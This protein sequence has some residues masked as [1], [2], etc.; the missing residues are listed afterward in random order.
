MLHRD[1]LKM[2]THE[3]RV[4]L[5]ARSPQVSVGCERAILRSRSGPWL[6]AVALVAITDQARNIVRNQ[7]IIALAVA[8]CATTTPDATVAELPVEVAGPARQTLSLDVSQLVLGTEGTFTVTGAEEGDVIDILRG[9]RI[10]FGYCPTYLGGNC[11]DITGGQITRIGQ[12]TAD[13]T[14]TAVYAVDLP[15]NPSIAGPH[16]F[17][18]VIRQGAAVSGE[19]NESPPILRYATIPV[20]ETDAFEPNDDAGSAASLSTGTTDAVSCV[21]EE[22]FYELQIAPDQILQVDAFYDPDDGSVAL[23][24]LDSAGASLDASAI[25]AS[26]ETVAWRNDLGVDETVTLRVSAIDDRAL[27]GIPYSLA[28]ELI[29]PAPC[30][31]DPHEPNDDATEATSLASPVQGAI[32]CAGDPD[33]YEI[34]VA[35]EGLID[36]DI[37]FD[38]AEGSVGAKLY[39]SAGNLLGQRAPGPNRID[40]SY[41]T[42]TPGSYYLHV[43]QVSDDTFGGG[44]PYAVQAV[45]ANLDICFSDL[46]EN[47]N[48]SAFSTPITAGLYEA[49]GGCAAD[50]NDW[51]VIDVPANQTLTVTAR[52]AHGAGN[53]D[54]RLY[55]LPPP[56]GYNGAIQS[57]LSVSDDES[58]TWAPAVDDRFWFVVY[59][60]G[61]DTMPISGGNIYDL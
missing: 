36:V 24:L 35:S 23:E 14:G 48:G 33:V 59:L 28:V 39:D 58:V 54:L 61:F 46:F 37:G 53:L 3:P 19:A 42:R 27:P 41:G 11:L 45:V 34:V 10:G 49:L 16:F 51:Y 60:Q 55:D 6:R 13:P 32:S 56:S 25:G 15:P 21:D 12:P 4:Q 40:L 20:C 26:D 8:G 22:D 5:P 30:P 38:P 18:A 44:V 29:T 50:T 9:S 43:E 2:H 7:L 17:Q 47:N 57:S 52:F 31:S 1:G